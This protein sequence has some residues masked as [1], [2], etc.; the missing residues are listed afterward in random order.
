HAST[1]VFG[2][3]VV[4]AGDRPRMGS[5]GTP[6]VRSVFFPRSEC[7]VLDTWHTSGLRGTGS[8][9]FVVRDL[10]VPEERTLPAFSA[11]PVQPGVL[12]QLPL[13]TVFAVSIAAVPLGIARA[14]I[15]VLVKL[16]SEK[17]PTGSQTLLRER[18]SI[19]SD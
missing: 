6:D 8:T 19:Q 10:F 11:A 15:D 4:M 3:C 17:T 7:E 9:D 5:D 16:A 14:A 1:W 2:N 18:A 12:Y 13:I